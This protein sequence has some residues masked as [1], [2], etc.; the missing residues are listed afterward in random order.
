[1]VPILRRLSKGGKGVLFSDCCGIDIGLETVRVV[2]IQWRKNAWIIK[3]H[4][5]YLNPTNAPFTENIFQVSKILNE[6]KSEFKCKRCVSAISGSNVFYRCIQIP[7]LSLREIKRAVSWEAEDLSIFFGEEY[8]WDYEIIGKFKDSYQ[9]FLAAVSKRIALDY[10]RVFEDSGL[11]LIALDVYPLAIARFLSSLDSKNNISVICLNEDS[12]E[13]SV[14]KNGK[15]IFTR[16]IKLDNKTL[17]DPYMIRKFVLEI[18]QFLKI[19][20]LYNEKIKIDKIYF[21]RSGKENDIFSNVLREIVDLP[22]D[23]KFN[24]GDNFKY[25][26]ENIDLCKFFKAIGLAMR[27]RYN[28]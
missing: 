26:S 6:I 12:C 21:L 9:I 10:V 18:V 15:L 11:E 24:V 23:E 16:H 28:R 22:V 27:G 19:K 8:V 2:Q 7:A 5:E 14:L 3:K 25:V 13:I 1:M 4:A 20:F 17:F